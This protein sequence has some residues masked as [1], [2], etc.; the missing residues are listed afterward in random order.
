MTFDEFMSKV[1]EVFPDALVSA[2]PRGDGELE[3]STGLILVTNDDGNVEVVPLPPE[4][5]DTP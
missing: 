1:L 2:G 3:V 4:N 5:L